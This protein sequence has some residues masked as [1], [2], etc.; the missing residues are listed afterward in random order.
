MITLSKKLKEEV[1]FIIN[2]VNEDAESESNPM[3]TTEALMRLMED[4]DNK[5]SAANRFKLELDAIAI[6]CGVYKELSKKD[7]DNIIVSRGH[8]Y[9]LKRNGKYYQFVSW[10]PLE[11]AYCDN[12]QL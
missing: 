2:C 1:D 12:R 8:K 5:N 4:C 3:T 11:E 10:Q 6:Q 7:L 9:D